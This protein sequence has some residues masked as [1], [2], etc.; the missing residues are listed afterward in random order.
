MWMTFFEEELDLFLDRVVLLGPCNYFNQ[1]MPPVDSP[2]W[3]A[4]K[5]LDLPYVHGPGWETKL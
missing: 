4:V 2:E 3:D 5:R 1:A